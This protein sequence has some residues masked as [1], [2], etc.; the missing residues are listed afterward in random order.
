MK[1][2]R[3]NPTTASQ[4]NLIKVVNNE[5][6]K[7]PL[8]KNNIFGKICKKNSGR[9]NSGKITVF[10]KGGGHK[11]IYRKVDFK[12]LTNST[13]IVINLEYD[14]YRNAYIIAL[15]DFINKTFKYNLATK[16][17]KIGDIV[18]TGFN[19]EP[20]L[21]HTLRLSKIPVGS[22]IHNIS[23]KP[24]GKAKITRAAGTVSQLIE[25]TD[26]HAQISLSSGQQKFIP[27]NC[28]ATVGTVSNDLFFLKTIGKAGRSRWLNKRPTVRGVAMNPIDHPH[29]GGEGK[30]SGGRTSVSPWGKPS[31][32][33]K[34]G[35]F[36]IKN[37]NNF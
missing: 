11:K 32:G 4:R 15:F 23:L 10:H 22:L 17:L 12:N 5:L 37:F 36:N 24:N 28:F 25:K 6:A 16:F 19:A 27:L 20:K 34:T 8:L 9:N 2:K 14:P 30:T 21:G 1:I 33:G 3:I 18:K 35:K 7:K 13:F 26:N 31:K 29:G